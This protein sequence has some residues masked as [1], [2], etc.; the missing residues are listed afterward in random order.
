[1][2][3]QSQCDVYVLEFDFCQILWIFSKT[4]SSQKTVFAKIKVHA[5]YSPAISNYCV[6]VFTT[7]PRLNSWQN[8]VK[9][10][11]AYCVLVTFRNKISK[12]VLYP[13]H[14]C[15]SSLQQQNLPHF[16]SC[17][18]R[19]SENPFSKMYHESEPAEFPL[20]FTTSCSFCS[21]CGGILHHCDEY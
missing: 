11:I 10:L 16:V 1:M 7:V 8:V 6:C 15:Y 21:C 4:G 2:Y 13:S 18:R 20:P 3:N 9:G 5:S 17:Q 12:H 14:Y 19:C